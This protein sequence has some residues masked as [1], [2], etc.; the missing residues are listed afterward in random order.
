M[1][2]PVSTCFCNSSDA[3]FRHLWAET[4][5]E[6]HWRFYTLRERQALNPDPSQADYERFRAAC[7]ERFARIPQYVNDHY[8]TRPEVARGHVPAN[9]PLR[10]R[11]NDAVRDF[12][13]MR[14]FRRFPDAQ[15]RKR[16]GT[17]GNQVPWTSM[18]RRLTG[19]GPAADKSDVAV[20]AEETASDTQIERVNALH[21][22]AYRRRREGSGTGRGRPY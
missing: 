7:L 14:A 12:V 1:S 2:M 9:V 8:A 22:D 4:I 15:G 5:V 13:I 19:R 6:S 18:I 16:L 11:V 3:G 10:S 20:A 17:Y 21:R